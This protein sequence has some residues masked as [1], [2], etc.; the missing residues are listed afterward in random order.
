M[1]RCCVDWSVLV[2]ILFGDITWGCSNAT[3]SSAQGILMGGCQGQNPGQSDTSQMR[4][5]LCHYCALKRLFLSPGESPFPFLSRTL[6]DQL[7][8]E[9][10]SAPPQ[11][12]RRR[13]WGASS[14]RPPGPIPVDIC[15]DIPPRQPSRFTCRGGPGLGGRPTGELRDSCTEGQ[16][17]PFCCKRIQG[18]RE[19][20]CPAPPPP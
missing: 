12:L 6:G 7:F 13:S 9:R 11:V 17:P 18:L 8:R 20:G 14:H 1:P 16:S 3:P 5:P 10:A 2:T 19:K 4:S 15:L